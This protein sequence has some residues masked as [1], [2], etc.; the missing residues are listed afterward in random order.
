MFNNEFRKVPHVVSDQA[1]SKVLNCTSLP[2]FEKL[3]NKNKCVVVDFT[4]QNCP[5][6][7]AISPRFEALINEHH[8]KVVGISVETAIARDI[9]SKY[10]ISATPT[11]I[12]FLDGK[13]FAVSKGAN[14][15][16]LK[17]KII[18]LLYAAYPPHKHSNL[19][20]ESLVSL[21][22]SDAIKF[23]LSSNIDMIYSK[24]KS[25]ITELDVSFETDSLN[26][27]VEF[28]KTPDF[29]NN[30]Q[31]PSSWQNAAGT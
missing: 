2:E 15:N 8:E 9:C 22:Q 12:Y 30:T 3:I 20:I 28:I 10:Q 27:L 11:F 23:T 19:N 16:E 26:H 7:R 1:V 25:F 17:S 14:E 29:K 24:L 13:Q 18:L 6:C 21:C 31:V 5:P 4:S